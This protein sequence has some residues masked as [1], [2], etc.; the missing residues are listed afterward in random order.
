MDSGY[1]AAAPAGTYAAIL[2]PVFGVHRSFPQEAAHRAEGRARRLRTW[3]WMH[4]ALSLPRSNLQGL[5]EWAVAQG[6]L[7]D[8][9][10]V[11]TDQLAWRAGGRVVNAGSRFAPDRPRR[12]G[13]VALAG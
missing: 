10:Q 13:T 6:A 2:T 3:A 11:A 12:Q 8:V 9:Q 5:A 7:A 1:G 4:V